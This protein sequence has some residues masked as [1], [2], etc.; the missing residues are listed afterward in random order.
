MGVLPSWLSPHF[1]TLCVHFV[2]SLQLTKTAFYQQHPNPEY[3]AI[4]TV[5]LSQYYAETE[6][7]KY[8]SVIIEV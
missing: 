2:P 3:L 6:D 4:Y 8:S 7:G 1:L 5:V